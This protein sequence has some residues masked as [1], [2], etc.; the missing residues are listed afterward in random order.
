MTKDEL[1]R[2]LEPFT[3]GL[4]IMVSS[5]EDS[6]PVSVE[7]VKYAWIDGNGTLVLKVPR[8]RVVRGGK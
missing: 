6:E 3:D 2:A 8:L 4:R 7:S 1:I 5:G